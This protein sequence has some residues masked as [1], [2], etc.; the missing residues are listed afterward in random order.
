MKAVVDASFLVLP[1]V[2]QHTDVNEK[3]A[4]VQT[5]L[6]KITTLLAPRLLVY[7]V[8]SVL[9]KKRLAIPSER[10][11]AIHEALVTDV[12]IHD[13]S[14]TDVG[15]VH[16]LAERHSLSFYDAAYLHVAL[17]DSEFILITHDQALEKAAKQELGAL[18]GL[19]V[20][21]AFRRFCRRGVRA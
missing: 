1:A 18:R 3:A 19:S 13:L 6:S 5:E 15:A 7:E 16:A 10:A 12:E 21:E 11:K 9:R 20:E 2:E 14:A 17:L 8:G 4:A